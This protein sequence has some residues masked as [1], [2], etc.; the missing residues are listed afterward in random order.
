MSSAKSTSFA[1]LS[2]PS[3]P[4][5]IVST[6]LPPPCAIRAAQLGSRAAGRISA[7]IDPRTDADLPRDSRRPGLSRGAGREGLGRLGRVRGAHTVRSRRGGRSVAAAIPRRYEEAAR[8]P[9]LRE[10]VVGRGPTRLAVAAVIAAAAALAVPS[11]ALGDGYC[12]GSG[13]SPVCG[14]FGYTTYPDVQ[15]ALNAAK[16]H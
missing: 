16:A 4:T 11:A 6:I 5:A 9:R 13:Q 14:A 7:P 8:H 1:A 3:V 15:S 10:R 12:V 2:D